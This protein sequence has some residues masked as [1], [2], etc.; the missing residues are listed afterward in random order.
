MKANFVEHH[1]YIYVFVHPCGYCSGN[2]EA[3]TWP[4]TK[5]QAGFYEGWE[6][7]NDRKRAVVD[8]KDAA[9]NMHFM[10]Y[11]THDAEDVFAAS[12]SFDL[13]LNQVYSSTSQDDFSV[14]S[15]TE[16]VES[17]YID[18][19]DDTAIVSYSFDLEDDDSPIVEEDDDDVIVEDDDALAVEDD[20]TLT[21]EEDD[22]TVGTPGRR[23]G[24]GGRNQ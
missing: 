24:G 21:V 17:T 20:D 18:L 19:T 22:D 12:Y 5:P 4:E 16:S 2:V 8:A 9:E 3:E 6:T 14:E 23:G 15:A 10:T 13:E 1:V 11:L 7:T